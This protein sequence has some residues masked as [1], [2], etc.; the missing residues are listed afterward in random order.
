MSTRS[1]LYFVSSLTDDVAKAIMVYRHCDGYPDGVL[2]DL[3]Q[4]F[5]DVISMTDDTRFGDDGYLAAKYVVWQGVQNAV[6]SLRFAHPDDKRGYLNFLSVGI[7]PSG[8][9]PGDVQYEYL[10]VADGSY[11][12]R[13]NQPEQIKYPTVRWR[14]SGQK[15][16]KATKVAASL[17]A[18]RPEDRVSVAISGSVS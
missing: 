3:G 10:I 7:L 2:P 6:A 5:H 17:K 16:W 18:G 4:F 11:S 15:A 1:V 12:R 8:D 13:P 9:V 14:E